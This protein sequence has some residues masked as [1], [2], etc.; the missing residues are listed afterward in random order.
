MA[1]NNQGERRGK[2]GDQAGAL[3]AIDRAVELYERL[4]KADPGAFTTPLAGVLNNQAVRRE[5]LGDQ[6]GA[7]AAIDHAVELYEEL[8]KGDPGAFTTLLAGGLNTQ[9]SLRSRAEDQAG[10][11]AAIDQAVEL[12]EELA[13]ADPAFTPELALA[14]NNQGKL[15]AQLGDRAAA[16]TAINEAVSLRLGLARANPAGFTEDLINSTWALADIVAE[17]DEIVGGRTVWEGSRAAVENSV[18]R[19][20][21]TVAAGLWSAVNDKEADAADL[22]RLATEEAA[23]PYGPGT[24][25]IPKSAVSDARQFV[26]DI[27]REL[28]RIAKDLPLW[29]TTD[30]PAPHIDLVN[31]INQSADLQAMAEQII[32][33]RQIVTSPAFVT[34]VRIIEFLFPAEGGNLPLLSLVL[35]QLQRSGLDEIVATMRRHHA[36]TSRI[37][38]WMRT[39]T[40]AD[41]IK[42]FSEHGTELSNPDVVDLLRDGKAR[43]QHLAVVLLAKTYS[44]EQIEGFL[45]DPVVAAEEGLHAVDRG[46][47]EHLALI[48]AANPGALELSSTGSLL[49]AVLLSS[50]G[51]QEDAISLLRSAKKEANQTQRKANNIH[52]RRYAASAAERGPA[53]SA[54][55][56]QQLLDQ[57][58]TDP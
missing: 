20:R 1:L 21:V 44:L 47:L 35:D 18:M 12:Y 5:E 8:A 49:V 7:L 58:S 39:Q 54:A 57:Y 25:T 45:T 51:Q 22:V 17:S 46:N 14:L 28:R 38:D 32:S 55:R 16:M 43:R 9:A 41:A 13:K 11:L 42:Y 37:D 30:I 52:L 53:E 23:G 48:L 6:A 26:R 33:H 4:A 3:A 50:N 36:A 2:L 34:T 27:A 31:A 19:S 24:P 10:A 56:A 29:V 40:W 15:R